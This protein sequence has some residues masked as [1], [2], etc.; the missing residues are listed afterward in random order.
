MC[1]VGLRRV[2][3]SSTSVLCLQPFLSA[4]MVLFPEFKVL[5]CVCQINFTLPT[6][7]FLKSWLACV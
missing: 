1:L 4:G 5:R 2:F 6:S 3:F 7:F